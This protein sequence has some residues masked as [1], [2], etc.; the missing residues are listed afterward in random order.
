MLLPSMFG[1][2]KRAWRQT[3]YEAKRQMKQAKWEAWRAKE[4]MREA[5]QAWHETGRKAVADE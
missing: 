1:R 4:Q 5:M 3:K 2:T